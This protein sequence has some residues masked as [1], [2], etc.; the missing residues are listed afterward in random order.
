[1]SDRGGIH[2]TVRYNGDTDDTFFGTSS[3]R[4]TLPAYTLVNV[5]A[6]FSIN[7]TLQVY[8]RVENAL[9]EDYEEV[10]GNRTPGTG[11]YVGLRAKF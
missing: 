9:D 6:D 1:M 5:G 7:D 4:V 10:Y 3:M 11:A 2:L 8:G